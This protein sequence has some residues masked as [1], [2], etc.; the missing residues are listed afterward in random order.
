MTTGKFRSQPEGHHP[1]TKVVRA[2]ELKKGDYI[3][4]DDDGPLQGG[5]FVVHELDVGLPGSGGYIHFYGRDK[6]SKW[7]HYTNCDSFLP[8][9][10]I[11][12][13]DE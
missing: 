10:K 7:T 3:L 1:R 11:V 9:Q 4:E 6:D 13:E 12:I 2:S 5:S 8:D